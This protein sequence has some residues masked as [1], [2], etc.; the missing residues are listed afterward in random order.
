MNI[1]SVFFIAVCTIA[2]TTVNAQEY[3]AYTKRLL[4]DEISRHVIEEC[5]L[6]LLYGKN[7]ID[8]DPY[9]VAVE[10]LPKIHQKLSKA[11][12]QLKHEISSVVYPIKSFGNY[13]DYLTNPHPLCYC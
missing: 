12:R 7:R 13:K 10:I 2:A 5:N 9:H 3:G 1:T 8:F 11:K 4:G 6:K